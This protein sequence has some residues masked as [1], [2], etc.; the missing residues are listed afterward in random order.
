MGAG[1]WLAGCEP[2]LDLPNNPRLAE[3]TA[4]S[5]ASG[6]EAEVR[7]DDARGSQAEP[8]EEPGAPPG[9]AGS[10]RAVVPP[11]QELGSTPNEPG[12]GAG[13]DAGVKPVDAGN[14]GRPVLEPEPIC[15]AGETLG[16]DARCYVVVASP[17]SWEAARAGCVARGTG[18]D[19]AAVRS[20]TVNELLGDMGAG[21]AWIGA[22]DAEEEGT[23]LW[24]N[25]QVPFWSGLGVSGNSLDGEYENWNSDEPNGRAG[26][27]CARLVLP[28]A[29][30]VAVPE[31][32][33]WADL[34]CFELLASVCEGPAF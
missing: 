22:S 32:P 19:L 8:G 26:S 24:V 34:E 13:A 14:A 27:N 10:P 2:L 11:R 20:P 30:N 4:P 9:S 33:T 31:L 17:L 12:S 18:W 25:E 7:S 6:S 23:W 28:R 5:Q 21:E 16:P 29:S 1:L 15:E 3:H